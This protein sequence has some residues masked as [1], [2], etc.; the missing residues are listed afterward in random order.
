M[1]ENEFGGGD[2]GGDGDKRLSVETMIATDGHDGSSLS[3]FIELPNGCVC[4]TVKDSLVETLET[5]LGRRSDLDYVLVECSGMADPG[6]VASVFWLDDALGSRLGLDGIVTCVDARNLEAQIRS[7]S[8]APPIPV[9][10]GDGPS[11]VGGGGDEAARQIA[12]ADRIIVNKTDL[13]EGSSS[14][15]GSVIKRVRSINPTAPYRITRYSAVDD[16]GWILDARCFDADRARDVENRFDYRSSSNGAVAE[17]MLGFGGGG[18]CLD[19]NCTA[20]HASAR[21]GR[22]SACTPATPSHRHTGSVGAI[23]LY[24]RGSVDLRRVNSWLASVL[25]P[26]QDEDDAVLTARLGEAMRR[27]RRSSKDGGGERGGGESHGGP[28]GEKSGG[29]PT[30]YRVKGVLSVRHPM[31]SGTVIPSSNEHVDDGLSDGSV[32]VDGTDGRRYIVQAV[33]DLWDVTPAGRNLDWVDDEERCCKVIVI[34]RWLD[35][36]VLEAGFRDCFV[37]CG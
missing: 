5:L 12:M 6:P 25:W 11:R 35:R 9:D 21:D 13:L 36:V 17:L 2:G 10:G 18:R 28:V 24:S 15:V 32:R 14:S 31:S 8:S 3:D 34:G 30:V 16:L 33:A 22:S 29:G 20:D 23:T 27:E 37:D 26:D 7:T 1:I 19:P 4:C